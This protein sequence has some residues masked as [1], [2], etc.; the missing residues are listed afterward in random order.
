M[1]WFAHFA[2]EFQGND[3]LDDSMCPE[4]G[5]ASAQTSAWLNTFAPQI[6][7]HLNS[8]APGAN[9]TNTDTFNLISLCP[10]ET[11]FLEKGSPFC[12]VFMEDQV[13]FP[14]FEYMGDLD[15]YYGT[16]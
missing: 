4:S 9:L 14:G 15:K 10:F 8:A 7:S 5:D 12:D 1:P 11:V 16:G 3:T 13:S 6:T 2:H